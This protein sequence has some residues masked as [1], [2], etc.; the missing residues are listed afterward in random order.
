MYSLAY[1]TLP[2]VRGVGGLQD[3]V[4][5][6][7]Q[8][9]EDSDGLIFY[10]PDA[11]ALLNILRRALLLYLEEPEQIKAMRQRGM[12]REFSWTKAASEYLHL[13]QNVLG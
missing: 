12:H 2:I 8:T 5:D 6:Y 3:T 4:I 9:P 1:G 11:N 10:P 13:Y 7:D